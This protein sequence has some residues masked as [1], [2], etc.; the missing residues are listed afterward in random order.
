MRV[1]LSWQDLVEQEEAGEFSLLLFNEFRLD[2]QGIARVNQVGC[3]GVLLLNED[4][5]IP[6]GNAVVVPF[7]ATHVILSSLSHEFFCFV[8]LTCLFR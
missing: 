1:D 8:N 4:V 3:L 6:T 5:T 7:E 2:I